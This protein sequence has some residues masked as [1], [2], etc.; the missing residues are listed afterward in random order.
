MDSLNDNTTRIV[1]TEDSRA[2]PLSQYLT[3]HSFFGGTPRLTIAVRSIL[4]RLLINLQLHKP[5]IIVR[6]IYPDNILLNAT[7]LSVLLGSVYDCQQMAAQGQRAIYLPLPDHFAKVDNPFLPPEYYHEPPRKH[8]TSFDIWQ[9]GILLLYVITGFLPHSYGSE[10]MKHVSDDAIRPKE[11]R[12]QLTSEQSELDDPPCYPR[13][14][15]FYDW[16]NLCPVV[17]ST[18]RCVGERGK[19]FIATINPG[20]QPSILELDNYKLLSCK[21]TKINYD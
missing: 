9:F 10:L 21:N 19:C 16:L 1:V 12:V 11:A 2:L 18:E 15:F 13:C 5:G 3:I 4:G 14:N 20:P 17:P 6:I 7:N 8:T